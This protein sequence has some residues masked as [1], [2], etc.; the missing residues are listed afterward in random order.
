MKTIR[1]CTICGNDNIVDENNVSLGVCVICVNDLKDKAPPRLDFEPPKL[2]APTPSGS[3]F[4]I[5]VILPVGILL[6]A[7]FIYI[8]M[9]AYSN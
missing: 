8:M 3:L 5:C 9:G 6:T 4:A 7:I 2:P 1:I